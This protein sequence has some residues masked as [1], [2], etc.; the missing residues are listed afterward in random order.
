MVEELFREFMVSILIRAHD[1]GN[2]YSVGVHPQDRAFMAEAIQ[3]ISGRRF[4]C[5]LKDGSCGPAVSFATPLCRYPVIEN[6]GL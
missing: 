1:P 4:G 2:T 3:N 5:D 6:G